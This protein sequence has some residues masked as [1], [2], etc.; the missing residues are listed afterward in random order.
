MRLVYEQGIGWLNMEDFLPGQKTWED[1]YWYSPWWPVGTID[2]V[3]KAEVNGNIVATWCQGV[4]T[5]PTIRQGARQAASFDHLD[6]NFEI[7]KNFPNFF[8]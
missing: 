3:Q 4:L 5:E 1:G 6:T 7:P 2:W 8:Q